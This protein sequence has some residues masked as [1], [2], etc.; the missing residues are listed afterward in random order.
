MNEP[1]SEDLPGLLRQIS[2]KNWFACLD[3]RP[4]WFVQVGLGE[5]A[6]GAPDGMYGVEYR[7]GSADRHFRY[8][9][10]DFDEVVSA[11]RGFADGHE[12][13]KAAFTRLELS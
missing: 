9:T 2:E 7:E 6:G 4:G 3:V 13:W 10:G 8:V 11:F 5:R 12:D 1:R